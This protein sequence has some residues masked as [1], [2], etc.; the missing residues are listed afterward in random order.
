MTT[1]AGPTRSVSKTC[2]GD[3][4]QGMERLAK[5][6]GGQITHWEVTDTATRR[7]MLELRL[8]APQTETVCLIDPKSKLPVS[9]HVTRGGRFGS[10]D[11]LK[12]ATEIR[13]SDSPPEGLFDFT[14]PGGATVSLETVEDPLRSLPAR[15]LRYCGEFHMKTVRDLAQ[16]QGLPVNTRMFFVDGAFVLRHGGFVGINNDSNE[17]WKDEIGV[18]NVDA[19]HLALFDATTGKKQKI[20]LVQHR[21]APPG[22]FRVFWQFEE[23][24][25]PGATRYGITWSGDAR[26][27][28]SPWGDG[29]HSLVMNNRFG[30]EG[31]ENFLL[32]VPKE[33]T[34]RDYS[35][36]YDSV[37]D[38][39]DYRVYVWQRRLPPQMIVNQVEV[40]LVRASAG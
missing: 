4:F 40:S 15:V 26:K 39:D 24:L 8:S 7:N 29:R 38:V 13:Y 20:R 11:I 34:I 33:M 3:F 36:V 22:R 1:T 32:I 5:T 12:H 23:P 35:R 30:C 16:P 17:I 27:L 18:F 25:L 19:P 21:L 2:L 14:I 31:I 6:L 37:A 28:E 9:I 10:C